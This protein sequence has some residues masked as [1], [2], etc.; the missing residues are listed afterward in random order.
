M[1]SNARDD[2][3]EPLSP[4]MTTRRSRGMSTQRFLRLCWRAPRTAITLLTVMIPRQP[5]VGEGARGRWFFPLPLASSLPLSGQH[6]E[7]KR[8]AQLGWTGVG[9]NSTVDIDRRDRA[10]AAVP[11]LDAQSGLFVLVDI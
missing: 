6:L 1:V 4:V 10:I 7:P 3:P 8:L 9:Q 11:L 5:R 2:F